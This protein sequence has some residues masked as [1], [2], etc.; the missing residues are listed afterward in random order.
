MFV[1]DNF[2]VIISLLYVI[3][4]CYMSVIMFSMAVVTNIGVN[5]KDIKTRKVS[6]VFGDS[7]IS[8]KTNS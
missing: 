5:E 6:A 1:N 2:H 4:L 8:G 7:T 3:H